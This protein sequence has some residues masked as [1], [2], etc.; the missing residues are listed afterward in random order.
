MIND[1]R[2]ILD[3]AFNLAQDKTR[4]Y[5][6]RKE[7]VKEYIKKAESIYRKIYKDLSF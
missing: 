6:E 7:K 2:N 5:S 4:K 3:L 1:F